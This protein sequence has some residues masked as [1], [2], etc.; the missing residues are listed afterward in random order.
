MLDALFMVITLLLQCHT[1][2]V[3]SLTADIT[4]AVHKKVPMVSIAHKNVRTAHY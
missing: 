2:Y 4:A 3:D 1:Y